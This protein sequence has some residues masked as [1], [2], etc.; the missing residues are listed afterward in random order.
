[1]AALEPR[2]IWKGLDSA[3]HYGSD[4]VSDVSYVTGCWVAG[5]F[6]P[7]STLERVLEAWVSSSAIWRAGS[8]LRTCAT[9]VTI[10]FPE[11]VG[12]NRFYGI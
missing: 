1:M 3:S 5:L 10:S 11:P 9:H 4:E 8:F 2:G 7:G 12:V 6:S